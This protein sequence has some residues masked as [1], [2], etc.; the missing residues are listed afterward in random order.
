MV[1]AVLGAIILT[2]GFAIFLLKKSQRKR[3]PQAV[4]TDQILAPQI[5]RHPGELYGDDGRKELDG[6]GHEAELDGDEGRKELDGGG[7]EAELD[8]VEI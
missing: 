1:G 7:H 8:G 3:P 6:G 5:I 2:I 4:P